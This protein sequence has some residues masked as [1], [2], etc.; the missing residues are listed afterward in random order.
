MKKLTPRLVLAAGATAL[1]LVAVVPLVRAA[2]DKSNSG[3]GEK[4]KHDEETLRRYD[5]N[6]NGKLDPDEEAALKA[7][8]EKAKSERKKK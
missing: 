7:D 2:S 1:A 4:K 8:R 3:G 6:S 5:R